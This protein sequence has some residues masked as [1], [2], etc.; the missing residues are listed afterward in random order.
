MKLDDGPGSPLREAVRAAENFIRG[1]PDNVNVGIVAFDYKAK[2]MCEITNDR[3]KARESLNRILAGIPGD[4]TAI[5]N[6]L[7]LCRNELDKGRE[8]VDKTVILFT[9]GNSDPEYAKVAADNLR[10]HPSSPELICVGFGKDI[11]EPLMIDNIAM[12]VDHYLAVENIVDELLE[13][14]KFLAYTVG[15]RRLIVGE[16]YEEVMA[17]NPFSLT[18]TEGLHPV[19]VRLPEKGN[20]V[21]IT[22]IVWSL[23]HLEPK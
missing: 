6:A 5:H 17:T 19:G 23:P 1:L 10:E 4:G 9:D 11:N 18:K 16:M 13:L 14:F 21:N 8:N 7:D 3:T 20:D 12:D 15:G 2:Q 22:T